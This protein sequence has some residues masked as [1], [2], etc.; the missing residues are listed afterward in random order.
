[1][2]A[3]HLLDVRTGKIL[4]DQ[5]ITVDGD[6]ITAVAAAPTT[7]PTGVDIGDLSRFTVVPGLIDV[8]THLT[9]SPEGIGLQ[10]LTQSVPRVALLGARNAR[11]TLEAGFTTVR[12][13]G[14]RGYSDVALRG[15]DRRGGRPRAAHGA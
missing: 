15:R 8:H 14:A 3:G 9:G 13:V 10:G 6:S 2:R 1:M 7:T 5:M 4:T 11:A 12:D